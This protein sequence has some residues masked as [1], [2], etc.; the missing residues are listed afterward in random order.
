[1]TDLSI[2]QNF[3]SNLPGHLS[4][5]EIIFLVYPVRK[6]DLGCEHAL[7]HER[8]NAHHSKHGHG[9]SPGRV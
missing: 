8:G 4:Q 6:I 7:F 2:V 5:R 9:C 3:I 1:M